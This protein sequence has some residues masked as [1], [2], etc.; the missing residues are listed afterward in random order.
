MENCDLSD[1]DYPLEDWGTASGHF[2]TVQRSSK[3]RVRILI[4][5]TQIP[6]TR[7]GVGVYADHLIAHLVP[8][9]TNHDKLIM[10]L[11]TDDTATIETLKNQPRVS[12]IT[13][14]SRWFR[15][16][17]I[18]MLFEQCI[19]P[20]IGLIERA[21]IIHSL[22]YTYPLLAF[23]RCVVTIHDLTFLLFPE[24]HT[25]GRRWIM[26]FFIRRAMKHAKAIIF[27]SKATQRDAERMFPC[28]SNVRRVAPLGVSPPV[29]VENQGGASRM[30]L[31]RM[32]VESPYLLFI[33][34]LEPRKNIVRIVEAFERVARKHQ[35]LTLVLAG[36][37]GWHTG[38]IVA[39]IESS[40][41]RSRIRHLGFV[42]EAEKWILLRNCE[43]L[44]YPSL[45]EGF[46]L[47][48]LEGMAAG[49]PVIT[50]NLSSMPEVAGD[51]A[52]LVDPNSVE[53][54]TL[55]I[56]QIIDDGTL[57]K[58]LQD[59]GPAQAALF[60]WQKMAYSTYRLYVDTL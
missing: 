50:S 55:A 52:F 51:A 10:L 4:D 37:L 17:A 34:T 14:P 43:M 6:L 25:L 59:A 20:F 22:H 41:M 12:L 49:A 39:R 58:R 30:A 46:G 18:L 31:S 2:R 23:S 27:V 28:G 36:K 7:T 15:N 45:Y 16:R 8:L 32:G 54:I 40:D 13:I 53:A 56:E 24:M 29:S 47:P 44:V 42:S 60:T 19:L 5:F 33:G 48:V 35:N 21:D 26:P 11:Q 3:R 38:E 57:I 1:L 9:L